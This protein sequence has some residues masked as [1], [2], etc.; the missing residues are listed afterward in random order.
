M[1]L[2]TSGVTPAKKR[3]TGGS[4]TWRWDERGVRRKPSLGMVGKGR[5]NFIK[6]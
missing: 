5:N 2:G 4:N 3:V 6:F 1:N